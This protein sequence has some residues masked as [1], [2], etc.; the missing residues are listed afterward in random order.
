MAITDG[1]DVGIKAPRTSHLKQESQ[2]VNV[3][4]VCSFGDRLLVLFKATL[5]GQLQR[6]GHPQAF[7]VA[8]SG[9][10]CAQRSFTG[11]L[12]CP[13]VVAGYDDII[14]DADRF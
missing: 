14:F 11:A 12:N 10:H 9:R 3:S 4:V 8:E 2:A 13:K 5:P 1:R 6:V 7:E